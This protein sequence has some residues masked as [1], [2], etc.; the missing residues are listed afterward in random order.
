MS[1][2]AGVHECLRVR[3]YE[4]PCTCVYVRERVRECWCGSVCA[5]RECVGG[6]RAGLRRGWS[7]PVWP[8]GSAWTP[9]ADPDRPLQARSRGR[10]GEAGAVAGVRGPQGARR[11][12]I[13]FLLALL[14]LPGTVV[15][16]REPGV[17]GGCWC[18]SPGRARGASAEGEQRGAGGEDRALSLFPE[19]ARGGHQEESRKPC[20]CPG[21]QRT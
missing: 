1:V 8:D 5:Q 17:R 9:T 4:S 15:L 6:R 18:P 12:Q 21:A 19:E 16:V 3:V 10:A 14:R 20:V 7:G 2:N 13:P 11:A